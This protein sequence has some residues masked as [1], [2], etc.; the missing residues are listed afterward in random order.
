MKTIQVHDLPMCCSTGICGT[1][2]NL[3]FVNFAA[4]LAA[5]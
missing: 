1:D 5:A 2:I 3:N 4:R